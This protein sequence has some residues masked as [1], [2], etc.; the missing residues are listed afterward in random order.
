MALLLK[1]LVAF[2]QIRGNFLLKSVAFLCLSLVALLLDLFVAFI[3]QIHGSFLLKFVI[4]ICGFF[5]KIIYDIFY[6][7]RGNFC[8][9]IF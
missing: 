1:L 5:I 9:V 2:Y 6:Q 3:Y 8:F 7:I 4:K